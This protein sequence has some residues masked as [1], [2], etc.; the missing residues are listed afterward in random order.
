MNVQDIVN[1]KEM[2]GDLAVGLCVL[3]DNLSLE[4]VQ[5][6]LQTQPFD[7][8]R[9]VVLI[10]QVVPANSPQQSH[11]Q[12]LLMQ[13]GTEQGIPVLYGRTMTAQY[14][15]EHVQE[16]EVAVAA[17]PIIAAAGIHGGLGLCLNDQEVLTAYQEGRVS[18][19][20]EGVC[21]VELRAAE[22]GHGTAKDLALY[23][24]QQLHGQA[25]GRT[26]ILSGDGLD[27]LD[28]EELEEL[29][30]TLSLT[31]AA[32]I[33]RGTAEAVDLSVD[34]AQVGAYVAQGG[35]AE[36]VT[37]ATQLEPV[38]IKS[39]YI[40]GAAGGSYR[41][42][43]AAAD[44]LQGQTIAYGTRLAVSPATAEVY[45]RIAD[46]GIIDIIL[47]AGGL[48][49]NQCADPAVQWRVGQNEVMV[50]NDW[51]CGAGYAGYD[52]SEIILASAQT[53][54]Q[55]ALTGVIGER[56][57][58]VIEGRCWAL[59]R[60]DIDTDIIIPTQYLTLP[61]DE[62]LTHTF[63]PLRPELASLLREGDIIVS[64]DNF[65]CGSSRE[66]AAE[67][68]ADS[69]VKCII[70]KSFARIFFRNA[71]NNGIL[72]IENSEIQN[73][74]KEGDIVRVELNKQLVLG[75]K[76]YPIGRIQDNIYEIIADG[77]LVKHIHK[78]V[79]RGEL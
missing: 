36:A 48:V 12:Q 15:A 77:G 35:S 60:D 70:A 62:M 9:V 52:T 69:G 50:S 47:D 67:V 26:L 54:A 10:D 58:P 7:K 6:L 5:Q 66:M 13:L 43:K 73:D 37:D 59:L 25:A 41:N 53:A 17:S 65:G 29:Y 22:E 3:N 24:V 11:L 45:Q 28:D 56:K 63:E 79:E 23:L 46:E 18:L 51:R 74:I 75:D 20:A 39:V 19:A 30:V 57:A 2:H 31:G 78:R 8:D 1:G 61:H 32:C 49:L 21:A 64:C 71:V 42:I 33:A 40:G 68:L 27:A 4:T 16:G 38:A 72:L 44:I 14:A 55:A 76:T 34:L